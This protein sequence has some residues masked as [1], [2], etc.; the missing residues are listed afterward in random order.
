MFLIEKVEKITYGAQWQI[1]S[2]GKTEESRG[3]D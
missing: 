1:I 3:A 2:R